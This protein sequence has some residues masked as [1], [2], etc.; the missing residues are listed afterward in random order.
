MTRLAYLDCIGGLAGDMLMAA[1]LDAGAPV[2]DLLEV[3][4]ALGMQEVSI[5]VDRVSRH[6]IMATTVRV[7]SPPDADTAG[8]PAVVLREIVA[9]SSLPAR[10]RRRSL[11]A[12]DRIATVEASIH[13]ANPDDVFLHELGGVDTLIDICGAFML[14][15]ALEIEQVVCSPVPY[16]RGL[17][18]AA[19]GVLPTPD[20]QCSGCCTALRWSVSMH[21]TSSSRRP[22]P[23]SPSSLRRRGANCRR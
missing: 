10:V 2:A 9:G 5:E 12:L 1:L 11:D 21:R 22:A 23:R 16:G 14:L 13:G 6:G 20:P 15:D 3:P 8:R 19:H 17:T 18:T 7:I 4:Q